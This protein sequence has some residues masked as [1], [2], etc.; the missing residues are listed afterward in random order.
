M[1]TTRSCPICGAEAK[2]HDNSSNDSNVRDY[3]CNSDNHHFSERVRDNEQIVV[4]YR[5]NPGKRRMYLKVYH[6]SNYSE[7][8]EGIDAPSRVKVEHIIKPDFSNLDALVNKL[9]TYLVFS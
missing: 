3:Y 9:R 4:K 6:L 7:I 5:I 1:N 8:W 2:L